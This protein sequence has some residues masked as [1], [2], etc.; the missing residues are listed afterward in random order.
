M[1]AQQKSAITFSL[2]LCLVLSIFVISFF[3]TVSWI[4][5]PWLEKAIAVEE[6]PV[7][8][9][10]SS[11]LWSCAVMTLLLSC[12]NQQHRAGWLI[13]G[14]ALICAALDERF[15]GHEQLKDWLLF[16]VFGGSQSAMGWRGDAVMLAYPIAG[17]YFALWIWKVFGPGVSRKLV[18][19]AVAVGSIAI[20]MDISTTN[21]S[22]QVVEE[23]FEALAETLFLS[24][25]IS[26]I[27]ML[28]DD[29]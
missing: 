12:I 19:A 17:L 22:W 27:T 3:A 5:W 10:Q 9:L 23:C 16:E 13:A 1:R 8:W 20:A 14:T 29:R 6:A 26:H 15:M 11:L 2:W 18:I 24:A 28:F 21:L 4:Y 7:A 25:L